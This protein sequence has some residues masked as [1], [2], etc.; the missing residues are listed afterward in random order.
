MHRH[1]SRVVVPVCRAPAGSAGLPPGREDGP[2]QS[3]RRQ[4]EHQ[5]CRRGI[6][7]DSDGRNVHGVHGRVVHVFPVP[8]GRRRTQ[9]A[10]QAGIVGKLPGPCRQQAARVIAGT[11]GK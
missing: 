6:V 9:V 7:A 3:V 4:I 2:C 5:E 10:F 8:R 11:R 1:I